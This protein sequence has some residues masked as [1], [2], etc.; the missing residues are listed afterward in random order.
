MLQTNPS[1]DGINSSSV[2]MAQPRPERNIIQSQCSAPFSLVMTNSVTENGSKVPK[3]E[4]PSAGVFLE[5]ARQSLGS[6]QV[7]GLTQWP[8]SR[9]RCMPTHGTQQKQQQVLLNQQQQPP[10]IQALTTHA[11]HCWKKGLRWVRQRGGTF[12]SPKFA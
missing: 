4:T 2:T 12:P 1:S 6:Q 3:K 11:W 9:P 5:V 8:D 7:C 10:P